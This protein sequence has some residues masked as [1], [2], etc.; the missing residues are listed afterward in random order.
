MN[1][2]IDLEEWKLKKKE[3]KNTGLTY[4][5]IRNIDRYYGITRPDIEKQDRLY[6]SSMA[7]MVYCRFKTTMKEEAE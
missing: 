4:Q 1:N 2:I 6:N 7:A 3:Y 5:Q